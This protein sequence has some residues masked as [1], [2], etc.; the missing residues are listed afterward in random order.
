MD[1]Q[2][3]HALPLVARGGQYFAQHTLREAVAVGNVQLG[4][5]K[6]QDVEELHHTRTGELHDGHEAFP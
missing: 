4:G 2:T 1:G 5:R 3:D 6:L